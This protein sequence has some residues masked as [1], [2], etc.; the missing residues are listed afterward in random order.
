MKT[1]PFL[2]FGAYVLW[3][4]VGACST[5]NNEVVNPPNNPPNNPTGG[6][7]NSLF[8]NI[9]HLFVCVGT[10]TSS[11]APNVQGDAPMQYSLTVEP[12]NNKISIDAEGK[13]HVASDT[14]TGTFKAHVTATN[15]KG[16]KTFNNIFTAHVGQLNTSGVS[17]NKDVKPLVQ[18]KCAT[19]HTNGG[20]RDW[21]VYSNSK[22]NILRIIDQV[23]SGNMPLG[24]SPL[25]AAEIQVFKDWMNNCFLESNP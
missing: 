4:F 15:S 1:K 5:S 8:Y 9:N 2:L 24:S 21:T 22:S 6:E 3:L 12:A 13:I 14:P 7:P 25:S 23:E 17:F 11:A 10:A 16:S 19:C 20:G 18:S